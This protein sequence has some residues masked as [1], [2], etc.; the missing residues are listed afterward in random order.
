MPAHVIYAY[1]QLCGAIPHT[2]LCMNVYLIYIYMNI[3]IYTE[4]ER[5]RERE[6][7]REREGG[8]QRRVRDI[9]HR[10]ITHIQHEKY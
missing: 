5:E 10:Y 1:L 4:R 8:G 2:H 3:C 9:V 7:E 6:S